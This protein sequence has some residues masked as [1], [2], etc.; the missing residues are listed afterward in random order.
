MS[1]L[2]FDKNLLINLDQSLPK[3]ILRTNM[4]GSYHC[5]TV[6]GCNTR[7]QHGL[8]V[9]PI[10]EMSN[11]NYVLLS[12]LDETVIQHGAPFN[13]GI[14]RYRNGAYS[15]NGHKYLRE[16]NCDTIPKLTYRVG[17][18]VL[19][20]EKVF[21]AHENRI[22]IRYTLLEAHSAT[23]LQFQPFLA[24]RN[25]MAL[26]SE[27]SAINTSFE[28]T[29]MVCHSACTKATRGYICNSTTS[30]NLSTILIGTTALNTSRTWLER[31]PTQ[32]TYGFLDIS[33]FQLRKEKASS[34][35]QAQSL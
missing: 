16:F 26:C 13:L 33:K 6:I 18:V 25:S 30:P 8:L 21:V 31:N 32:K 14:H 34:S 22:M 12:S 24:F 35:R 23:T 1:Y 29:E 3:E 11:D 20:K 17:G 9:T 15:P 19:T 4:A 5:T 2:K 27:N 10:K 7:K 28:E